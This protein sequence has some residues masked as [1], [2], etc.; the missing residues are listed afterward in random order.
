VSRREGVAV[1]ASIDARY[2]ATCIALYLSTVMVESSFIR[3]LSV[4][5]LLYT[6]AVWVLSIMYRIS[7]SFACSARGM[8]LA[9]LPFLSVRVRV[10]DN[11]E[12]VANDY[13][14]Q[15]VDT[16]FLSGKISLCRQLGHITFTQW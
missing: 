13:R 10:A 6:P 4:S 11:T 7:L 5:A 12:G 15:C 2:V 14:L 16:P 8:L 3:C 9:F 1:F